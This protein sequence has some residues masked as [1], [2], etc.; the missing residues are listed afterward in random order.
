MAVVSCSVL[1]LADLPVGIYCNLALRTVKKKIVPPK[2][3]ILG[4]NFQKFFSENFCP[5]RGGVGQFLF[6]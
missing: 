2:I 4:Q 1:L 5:M 6:G 3:F